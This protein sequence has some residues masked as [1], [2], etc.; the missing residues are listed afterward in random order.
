MLPYRYTAAGIG[1]V[2]FSEEKPA[3]VYF[4]PWEIDREQPR[5]TKGFISTLR[6]YRGL[7]AMENKIRR[8]IRQFRF[9]TVASVFP[10]EFAR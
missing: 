5:L 8:L 9:S 7:D 1:R 6:A 2:N 10:A 3:C 4:H